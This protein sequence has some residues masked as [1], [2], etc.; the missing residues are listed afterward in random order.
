MKKNIIPFVAH[1][2]LVGSGDILCPYCYKKFKKFIIPTHLKKHGK[3][4]KDVRLEFPDHI[5][6]SIEYYEY[7]KK[8]EIEKL[9]P[10]FGNKKKIIYCCHRGDGDCPGEP[11]ETSIYTN[12]AILCRHCWEAGKKIIDKRST[13]GPEKL[14]K[15]IKSVYG[16]KYMVSIPNFNIMR[17]E[18]MLKRY[19]SILPPDIFEKIKKSS[20]EE[21][22][23]NGLFEYEI[24][25]IKVHNKTIIHDVVTDSNNK[26]TLEKIKRNAL[27]FFP[28]ANIEGN[29]VK[30]YSLK[31]N[32]QYIN[33]LNLTHRYEKEFDW[34]NIIYNIIPSANE[35]KNDVRTIFQKEK[36]NAI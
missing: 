21:K 26:E 28:D 33:T 12:K 22:E 17:R 19:G 8:L 5:T 31:I 16:K 36:E 9:H 34:K 24:E 6:F 32:L 3:N 1:S 25:N 35:I 29:R 10:K 13:D 15:T 20:N 30:I 11:I 18:L 27:L 7:R 4:L 23:K 14:K 2:H